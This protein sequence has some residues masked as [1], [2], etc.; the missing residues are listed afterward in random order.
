MGIFSL[1]INIPHSDL[2][3]LDSHSAINM[4]NLH[5]ILLILKHVNFG[6]V[7]VFLIVYFF[8][9]SIPNSYPAFSSSFLFSNILNEIV[10]N[11]WKKMICLQNTASN[12]E[13]RSFPYTSTTKTKYMLDNF[14]QYDTNFSKFYFILM[15]CL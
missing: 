12:G 4:I 13:R 7:F 10:M 9:F 15:F 11:Q 1:N 6:G 3:F 5:F 2:L 14:V 8:P